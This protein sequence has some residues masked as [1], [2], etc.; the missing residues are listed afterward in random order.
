MIIIVVMKAQRKQRIDG[1]V[2][3]LWSNVRFNWRS[4]KTQE[5]QKDDFLKIFISKFY[6]PFKWIHETK[7]QKQKP[8]EKCSICGWWYWFGAI[9]A[10][11][12]W[13]QALCLQQSRKLMRRFTYTTYESQ[14]LEHD[15]SC[16]WSLWYY[17]NCIHFM[18][19]L[20]FNIL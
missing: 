10:V 17:H 2:C 8:P 12:D 3:A 11:D 7:Q 14:I 15:F 13:N 18:C 16:L 1:N 19:W 6:I 5:S 4:H 20:Y 9:T